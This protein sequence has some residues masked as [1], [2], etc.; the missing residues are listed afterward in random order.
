MNAIIRK[1]TIKR[2]LSIL[3]AVVMLAGI[4]PVLPLAAPDEGGAQAIAD[5]LNTGRTGGNPL[6]PGVSATTSD[7]DSD[8]IDDTVYITGAFTTGTRTPPVFAIPEGI[9]VVWQADIS[10]SGTIVTINGGSGTFKLVE[11]G[12]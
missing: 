8:G 3:L 10:T 1:E 5:Y 12:E 7:T 2:L 4:I 11:G 9:T 6:I